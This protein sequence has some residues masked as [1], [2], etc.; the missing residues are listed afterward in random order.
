MEYNNHVPIK[1]KQKVIKYEEANEL[2]KKAQEGCKE[3]KEKL[4]EGNIKLV[5]NIVQKFKNRKESAEDLFQVGSIG[6]IKAIDNFDLTRGLRFSTYA[7][8]MI[9]GEI[10]RYLRDNNTMKV[11]RSIKENIRSINRFREEYVSKNQQEPKISEISKSLNIDEEDIV[12]ALGSINDIMSLHTP[13][14]ESG[15]DK[16][17]TLEEKIADEVNH[18]DKWVEKQY[19]IKCVDNLDMKEKQIIKMRYYLN[20]TQ[21]QIGKELGISQAH[22]SRIEKSA[23]VKLRKTV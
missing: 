1:I 5:L 20:K 14:G 16:T 8:P 15:E 17:Q 10:K 22:V 13:I 9:F 21:N 23:L 4:I 12:L 2:I 19:L 11:S 3:S 7:V 18:I 6:L